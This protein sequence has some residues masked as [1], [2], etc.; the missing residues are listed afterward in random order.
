MSRHRLIW[1]PVSAPSSGNRTEEA[2]GHRGQHAVVLE[3]FRLDDDRE[4][5]A[6][7]SVTERS[8]ASQLQVAHLLDERRVLSPEVGRHGDGGDDTP[9]SSAHHPRLSES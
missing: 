1:R 2:E 6:E 5:R 8:A 7:A 9:P 4:R 3:R